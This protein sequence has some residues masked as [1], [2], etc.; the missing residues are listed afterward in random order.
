MRQKAQYAAQMGANGHNNPGRMPRGEPS[1]REKLMMRQ[2]NPHS[3]IQDQQSLGR[4]RESEILR[5]PEPR[6]GPN[7]KD[8][9]HQ[10]VRNTSILNARG[11]PGQI[12]TPTSNIQPFQGHQNA[13]GMGRIGPSALSMNALNGPQALLPNSHP[14]IIPKPHSEGLANSESDHSQS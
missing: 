11:G 2:Q 12:L 3:T 1:G 7:P 14:S 5:A 4:Q 10:Q 13:G 6:L 8:Q 9:Y